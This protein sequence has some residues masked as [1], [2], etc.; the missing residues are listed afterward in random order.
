MGGGLHHS[1]RLGRGGGRGRF[2]GKCLRLW[3]RRQR[4]EPH[5]FGVLERRRR[6]DLRHKR[7]GPGAAQILR[8]HY[9][10]AIRLS[11]QRF[12]RLGGLP[13][14]RRLHAPDGNGER[15]RKHGHAGEWGILQAR[16][17]RWGQVIHRR[18]KSRLRLQ[19]LHHRLDAECIF[20][21]HCG[22]G[23]CYGRNL[24]G[25]RGRAESMEEERNRN[26]IR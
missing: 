1:G 11:I 24:L 2:A 9:H 17:G 16:L 3:Q 26:G 22:V 4:R 19:L 14:Q 18:F 8:G 6:A 5:D 21:S 10:G 15:Q 7:R 12:L 23:I 20:P 25:S 13:Q